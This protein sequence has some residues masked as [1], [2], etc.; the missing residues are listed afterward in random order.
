MSEAELT[1]EVAELR[2]IVAAM[3][4]RLIRQHRQIAKLRTKLR[5]MEDDV[6]ELMAQFEPTDLTDLDDDDDLIY[7]DPD[8]WK[9]GAAE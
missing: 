5:D 4:A 9:H 3:D 2:T 8:F 6:D 1:A 7:G